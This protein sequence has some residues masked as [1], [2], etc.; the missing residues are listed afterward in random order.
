MLKFS[1]YAFATYES[2]GRGPSVFDCWGA[3]RDAGHKDY[4]WPLLESFGH[5]NPDDKGKMTTAIKELKPLFESCRLPL[6]SDIERIKKGVVVE[7]FFGRKSVH[8]GLLTL[9]DGEVK[10][11]HASKKMGITVQTVEQFSA[12]AGQKIR[13]WQY[14]G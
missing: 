10:V 11:F 7:G 8:V 2:F 3:V 9:M 6:A 5:V 4:G 13:F 1:R 14:V 12:V